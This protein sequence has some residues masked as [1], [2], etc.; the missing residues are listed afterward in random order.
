MIERYYLGAYWWD[1]K[2]SSDA[3]AERLHRFFTM[4]A[5]CDPSFAGWYQS[6]TSRQRALENELSI[7]VLT[8][9]SLLLQGRNRTDTDG[10]VISDLG[11]RLSAWNGGRGGG[12]VVLRVHCGG[13]AGNPHIWNSCVIVLPDEGSAIERVLSISILQRLL[14]AVILCFEPDWATVIP[15][16]IRDSDQILSNEPLSST[17]GSNHRI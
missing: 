11:F 1:R 8:L 12:D 16:S 17:W 9:R 14:E 13:H 15:E 7:D 6:G 10:T 3:C 2:E 4:V 5:S